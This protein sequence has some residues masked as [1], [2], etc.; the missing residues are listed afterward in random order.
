VVRAVRRGR[1]AHAAVRPPPSPVP[2]SAPSQEF[3]AQR[4]LAPLP[5]FA[6]EPRPLGSAASDRARDY[7]AGALRSAEF[8]VQID[9]AV[10]ASSAEGVAAFGRVDNIVATLPGR[11]PTGSV[12][13]AAHYDSVAA[14]P[15]ASDDG[16]AIAAMLETV[17]ALRSD[18]QL[19][20]DL[21]LLIT[22]GEEAGLLGAAEF[23][24]QHPRARERAVVSGSRCCPSWN[25]SSHRGN[26]PLAD[27]EF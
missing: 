21:V 3:S 2:A 22:D 23:A 17:R 14:G 6:T 26:R 12:V 1:R 4:A 7:L 20:N 9:R 13:L 5:E 15:G 10:G 27:A 24:R 11:D 25:C 18:D 16:A 19:R 8:L